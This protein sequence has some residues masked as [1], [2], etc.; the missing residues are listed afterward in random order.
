VPQ[1]DQPLLA[2]VCAD[3]TLAHEQDATGPLGHWG[4]G[5]V[6]PTVLTKLVNETA[7]CRALSNPPAIVWCVHFAPEF[8]NLSPTLQLIDGHELTKAAAQHGVRFILCG[9]THIMAHGPSPTQPSVMIVCA[10]SACC[11][12]PREHTSIH[13]LDF[14]IDAGQIQRLAKL[15]FHWEPGSTPGTGEFVWKPSESTL[16]LTPD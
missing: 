5:R 8:P 10:G 6:Y 2:L 1:T 7:R 12:K 4:Q 3:F 9:H 16:V 13:L 14:N 15:D 11:V